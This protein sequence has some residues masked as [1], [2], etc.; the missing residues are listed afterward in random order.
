MASTASLLLKGGTVLQHQADDKVAVLKNTDILI[1]GNKIASI[2]ASLSAPRGAKVIDC[3]GKIVSPGMIDT[4]NHLWLTQMKARHAEHTLLEYIYKGNMQSFNFDADD[5]FW[6]QLG[7][8][9][10]SIDAGT[11][12][13]VD[14]AHL[15][16]SANHVNK[17]VSATIASGLRSFFCYVPIMRLKQWE[18]MAPDTDFLPGWLYSQIERLAKAQPFGNGRVMLGFGYDL[19][20]LPKETVVDL[21]EK[22]RGWGVNLLTTHYCRNRIFGLQSVPSILKDYGLLKSDVLVAHGS[23]ALQ[24]DGKLLTDAGVYVAATPESEGQ[25][26]LGL[27][28]TFRK[29]FQ[30]ALGVDCHFI[31]PPDLPAQMRLALQLARATHNQAILDSDKFPH[32]T[33]GNS[34]YV[35]NLGTINGARA[36]NMEHQIGSIAVGKLADLV[37]YDAMSPTM[38][39]A[40]EEDP[41]TAIVRHSTIRDVETVII[42]GVVRKS[43]GKLVPI[44]LKMEESAEDDF[45]PPAS[46][47]SSATLTWADVA[48]GIMKSREKVIAK[49]AGMD[50]ISAEK[51]VIGAFQV[52]PNILVS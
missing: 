36:V 50:M 5:M 21:W 49:I 38:L 39:C 7:G 6:G 1:Q 11:T 10:E 13:V 3:T 27:P 15:T 31:G 47:A 51:S 22:V 30:V 19:W 42:D 4:H 24:E 25:M 34:A 28:V 26:G 48:K 33:V 16:Y 37:I 17:A 29:G 40:A 23:Q 41:V 9:L 12:T 45:T 44:C 32:K 20:M 46:I 18:P 43:A 2:G 52:D 14:F 8:C 35:Y